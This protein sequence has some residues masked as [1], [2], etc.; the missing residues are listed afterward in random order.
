M[1]IRMQ[2]AGGREV[3]GGRDAE[4]RGCVSRLRVGGRV[5]RPSSQR[6][7]SNSVCVDGRDGERQTQHTQW[8]EGRQQSPRVE[9]GGGVEERRVRFAG[10]R[11]PRTLLIARK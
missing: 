11:S 2:V 5:G 9:G 1:A 6:G 3:R 4:C 10:A 7:K 8:P